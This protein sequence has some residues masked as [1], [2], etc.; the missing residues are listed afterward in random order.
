MIKQKMLHS[1]RPD[2]LALM[3]SHKP[4]DMEA[5][6]QRLGV[7]KTTVHY[8]LRETG[9]VSEQTRKKILKVAEEVGYRP[10]GLARGLRLRKTKTIG[11]ILGSL[12]STF[13]AHVLE[14]IDQTAQEH[15]YTMLLSCSYGLP[16]KEYNIIET[17]LERGVDGLI[18]A[19]ADPE[20]NRDH[21]L[22][23]LTQNVKLVFV[24]R[25]VPGV[26]VDLV[27]SD[28]RLGAFL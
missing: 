13:H 7:S 16:E 22:H 4:L 17:L 23:L 28:N 6:A 9:R 14:G 18:I 20:A 10:N 5:I 12:T 2:Q 8:A 26:N 21:F 24:D 25:E 3:K 27:A 15:G 1:S 19:P 11:I